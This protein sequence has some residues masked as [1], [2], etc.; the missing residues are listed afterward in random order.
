VRL[1]EAW[2]K[3]AKDPDFAVTRWLAGWAPAGIVHQPEACG[4]FPDIDEE[5]E[6][7]YSELQGNIDNFNNYAGVDENPI[8]TDEIELRLMQGHLKA[9]D[10]ALELQDFVGATTALP[11]ILSK[12]GIITK[13][14]AGKMK[15]RMIL[16]TKAALIKYVSRKGQRVILPR[17]L[18]A[19]LQALRL[20]G[21]CQEGEG[22]EWM[23]LDF[24]DAFWQI[25]LH[26]EERKFF[27]CRIKHKGKQKYIVFLSTAQGSR[28]A[29][30][31][32][33]RFAALVMRLTQSLFD[34]NS[35]RLQ[36]FVDDPI[37]AIKG[38][39]LRRKVVIA[40]ITL[41]WE[42]LGCQLAYAK[43]QRGN[44]A[45]WIGGE[46]DINIDEGILTAQVKKAIV[47]D[48]TMMLEEFNTVNLIP[49]KK[50]ESFIG[51]VNHAAGLLVTI[52]PFLQSLWAALYGPEGKVSGT[53]WVKQISHSL[54]WL[55]AVFHHDTPGLVRRFHLADFQGHGDKIE[56]GTDASP[57]GLGGWL[58]IND[59]ITK[60]FFCDL[61]IF[62][63]TLYNLVLGACEGQQVLE[64]LAILVAIRGWVPCSEK[65]V[66]LAPVVRGDNV[67]A[68]LWF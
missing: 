39:E 64:C 27:C 47:V 8:A 12:I 50:L 58:A 40:V 14:R 45:D 54:S 60:Y 42:A 66:Q 2:R 43:G 3:Q 31:T 61:S 18:D 57:W 59:V 15:H 35:L 4:I 53:V 28:G 67:S 5:A 29:P 36:C 30:L 26:P 38:S 22:V 19:I 13:L 25:R 20:M 56:I 62:D 49:L 37:A 16:D 63:I 55:R 34:R 41:V 17:L 9:F 46:L 68:L 32:W 24:T 21:D 44:A 6:M 7:P 48:I 52:R 10:T 33:A 11:V 51:K 23:V 1:L 65:R